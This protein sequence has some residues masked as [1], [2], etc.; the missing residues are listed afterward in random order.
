MNLRTRLERILTHDFSP[1]ANRHV[2]W[3]KSPLGLLIVAAVVALICGLSIASQ[4]FVVFAAIVMVLGVGII[5]P[6]LGLCGVACELSFGERRVHEGEPVPVTVSIVNRWPIPVWGLAIEKRFFVTS[7]SEAGETAVALAQIGPWSKTD[8]EWEFTP[9]CRGSYPQSPPVI[10]TAFP[11]GLWTASRPIRTQGELLVWP[12]TFE[13]D[14]LPLPPGRQLCVA[15][16]SDQRAGTEGETIGARPYRLGDSLRSVHWALTA[17]HDRFLVRERQDSAQ[18][19]AVIVVEASPNWHS[20]PGGQSSLEWSIRIAASA[21]AV[22]LEQGALVRLCIGGNQVDARPGNAG[23]RQVLDL[24]A[25][26][27]AASRTSTSPSR[28]WSED[29]EAGFAIEIT[30]DIARRALL[31]GAQ[32]IVL[33]TAAFGANEDFVLHELEPPRSWIEVDNPRQV[34]A[35]VARQWRRHRQEVF[36][37]V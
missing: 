34:P 22:L 8:F 28:H 20:P 15:T 35:Q 10:S 1:W 7:D 23:L 2:Y 16:A 5:W 17:R 36:R 30:T 33:N 29:R 18:S 31:P 11:F 9:E 32:Q 24:L 14:G 12:R 25:R 6:R 19:K 26:F 27:D 3:L 13:L 21:A 37:G 4:G